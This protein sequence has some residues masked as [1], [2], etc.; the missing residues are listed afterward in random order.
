MEEIG[1]NRSPYDC[2]VYYNK[3]KNGSLIYLVL[4]VDDMLIATKNKSNV[5]RLKG[6]LSAEFEMKDLGVASKI[7]GMEIYRD[8]NRKKLFLSQKG[9]IQKILSRFGM[10]TAKAVDTPCAA[11]I[12]LFVA[13]SPKSIEEREYMSR[14][15]YYSAV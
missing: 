2:C 8:I 7:L 11:S 13:F 14:V 12:H 3:A 1:Y 15:P 4:Y 6:L 5:Q 9:Y 10:S